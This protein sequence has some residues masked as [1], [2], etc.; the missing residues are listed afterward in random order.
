MVLFSCPVSLLINHPWYVGQ[1]GLWHKDCP[2]LTVVQHLRHVPN[3]QHLCR[4]LEV[5]EGDDIVVAHVEGVGVALGH[6][7][8]QLLVREAEQ[9][10]HWVWG[11]GGGSRKRGG[12]GGEEGH[13]EGGQVCSW[14]LQRAAA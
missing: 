3:H 8:L 14:V 6:L 2:C 4:L 5:L 11:G 1:V 12:G 13:S 9:L 7:L 10:E